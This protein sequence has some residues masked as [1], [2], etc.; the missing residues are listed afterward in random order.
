MK[1]LAYR[2]SLGA[3]VV[4]MSMLPVLAHAQTAFGTS[5]APTEVTNFIAAIA[6]IIGAVVGAIL[7][8]LGALT[9]LGWGVRKFRH[10]VAGRKF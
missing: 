4:G 10:Y 2:V 7:A 3:S 1:N 9:G 8:L 6:V 5:T